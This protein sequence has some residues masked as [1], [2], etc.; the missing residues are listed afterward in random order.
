[1][2]DCWR[3]PMGRLFCMLLAALVGS[4]MAAPTTTRVADTVYRADGTPA[5]GVLL[6]SWPAFSTADGQAVAAGNK[7]VTLGAQGSL[8]VDLVPNI[9]SSPANTIYTV[10]FQLD[11]G[12]KTEF[13]MVP[14][15]SPVTVA[16]IRTTLGSTSS[17][18]QMASRQ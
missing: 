9:G 12:A 7:S 13:W 8:S 1:M 5:T 2:F 11:D 16:A 14:T 6:I 3:R 10:V 15:T 18:T 4:A 17:A